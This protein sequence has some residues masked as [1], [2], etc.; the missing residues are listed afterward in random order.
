MLKLL[1]S[2]AVYLTASANRASPSSLLQLSSE[3]NMNAKP[4]VEGFLAS[5]QKDVDEFQR[6][7]DAEVRTDEEE[8]RKMVEQQHKL[9]REEK[10]FKAKVFAHRDLPQAP[11][12][13]AQF[14]T[15]FGDPYIDEAM[16]VF[17]DEI[18]SQKRELER[19]IASHPAPAGALVQQ[20]ET[21]PEL[22][23]IAD[24]LTTRLNMV[25]KV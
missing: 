9:E 5:M 6:K 23:L 17:S 21:R 20:K 24:A 15:H 22:G 12:S 18:D 3:S 7:M 10:E 16:R 25:G 13:F 2:T 11:S 1:A 4:G 8:V 14:S 19:V